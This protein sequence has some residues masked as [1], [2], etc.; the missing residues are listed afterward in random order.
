MIEL[1]QKGYDEFIKCK[2]TGSL[3]N[4]REIIIDGY[5]DINKEI[6]RRLLQGKAAHVLVTFKRKYN[7][8]SKEHYHELCKE[9]PHAILNISVKE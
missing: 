3:C 8:I 5:Q 7:R 2:A 4:L 6:V 1:S 9:F